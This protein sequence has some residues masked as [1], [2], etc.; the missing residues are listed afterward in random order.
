MNGEDYCP[1][2]GLKGHGNL[3]GEGERGRREENNQGVNPENADNYR[4]YESQKV[5][6]TKSFEEK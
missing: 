5:T 1:I 3:E 2:H 6:S 4:F